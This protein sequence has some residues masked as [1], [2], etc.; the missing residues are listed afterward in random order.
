MVVYALDVKS[1][2]TLAASLGFAIL[3]SLTTSVWGKCATDYVK[4]QGKIEC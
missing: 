1:R 2:K 3:V 4:I